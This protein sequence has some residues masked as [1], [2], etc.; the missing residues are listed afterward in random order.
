[1][2][3]L[4][5]F[6]SKKFNASFLGSDDLESMTN[7]RVD[8]VMFAFGRFQV[9]CMGNSV[10][11]RAVNLALLFEINATRFRG[12]E[13]FLT[14]KNIGELCELVGHALS[15]I[16]PKTE[17]AHRERFEEERTPQADRQAYWDLES[18]LLI[19]DTAVHQLCLVDFGKPFPAQGAYGFKSQG[20]PV[21]EIYCFGLGE[22]VGD[23]SQ[24]I[25]NDPVE[26]CRETLTETKESM[27]SQGRDTTMIGDLGACLYIRA[28]AVT[29]RS[30]YESIDDFYRNHS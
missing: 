18:H 11:H 7:R 12:G 26:W 19:C 6:T 29:L 10:I 14:P 15:L 23:V 3:I 22:K 5:G 17:K 25:L 21:E 30:A 24:L 20:F 16:A 13:R 28:G 4:F 27:K 1:M 2:T 9:A 8:K